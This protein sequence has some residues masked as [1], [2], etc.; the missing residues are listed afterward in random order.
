MG[1]KSEVYT[2]RVTRA[3]K[4]SL[5]EAARNERRSVAELLEEVVGRHLEAAGDA[6]DQ[7]RQRRLHQRAAR[8]AGGISG[9]DP[10]RAERA[11]EL[12]RARTQRA[13]RG[14]QGAR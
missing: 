11:R 2:W 13:R 4:T 7:A 5:E 3:M 14:D 8:Y 10:R 9:R 6:A 1:R 12:V